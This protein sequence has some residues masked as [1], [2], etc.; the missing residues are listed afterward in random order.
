ML[1][2]TLPALLL[3]SPDS[4]FLGPINLSSQAHSLA[5]EHCAASVG[6]S[7]SFGPW[8]ETA[9]TASGGKER[10]ARKRK[11]T[12]LV[13]FAE[14]VQQT[15][16]C[17]ICSHSRCMKWH[18]SPRKLF[19]LT[20]V[21]KPYGLKLLHMHVFMLQILTSSLELKRS[22]S[23]HVTKEGTAYSHVFPSPNFNLR[24]HGWQKWSSTK[25]LAQETD[26]H[27][28]QHHLRNNDNEM[29]KKN[30]IYTEGF[31]ASKMGQ[32]RV[33]GLLFQGTAGP[34]HFAC[35]LDPPGLGLV[36]NAEEQCLPRHC[37][38]ILLLVGVKHSL[39]VFGWLKGEKL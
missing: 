24:I 3:L 2:I 4:L 22:G 16:W 26:K 7:V 34:R 38:V 15:L 23:D 35:P 32:N 29:S 33:V 31:I 21:A 25:S 20:S 10:E 14:L 5:R 30:H 39:G 6:T 28:V 9:A 1:R 12:T 37:R 17:D 27:R 13:S 19:L 11:V 18:I 8:K 36:G